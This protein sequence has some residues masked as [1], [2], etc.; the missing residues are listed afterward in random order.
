MKR[1]TIIGVGMGTGTL[2]K[3]GYEAIQEAE[4][5]LGAPRLTGLFAE[6]GK[7]ILNEYLPEGVLRAVAESGAERLAVLVS[8]DAGFYSAS[9]ALVHALWEYE[10][11]VLPGVSSR[12]FFF[13]RLKR[14]Y[15]D[16]A[17]VSCHG[18]E[19][20]LADAVRRNRLTFALTGGN[21]TELAA[22]L[23]GAGFGA[24]TA[25]AG[26]NLGAADERI[27]KTVVSSLPSENIGKLAV[28]LIENPDFDPRIRFGIPD[29]EFIRGDVPMTKAEVR[30]TTLS[31]LGLRPG[32][33]CCDVG[34]GTGSVS[35]EMAMAA[36][37]GRVYAVDKSA[38]ALSLT[39]ENA[40]NFH[41]GNIVTVSGEA[42]ACLEALPPFD[43]AFI[44][45]SSGQMQEI[46]AAILK[47]NPHA[48]IVVNAVTLEGLLSA[49]A[50]F[51]AFGLEPDIVQLSVSS[52]KPIGK[53]HMMNAQN[54]VFVLSGGGEAHE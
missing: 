38:E 23:E 28:L 4:V 51:S 1:I 54:P 15:Q 34:C 13:A 36:Y 2:T 35:V 8:G 45:G 18:R 37:Q 52:V 41:I 48:R 9:D 42:P 16:A 39:S 40:R 29:G 19:G 12:S 17:V 25:F 5:L 22:A 49:Q 33:V 32:D 6:T 3:E 43:A 26:E 27:I 24:L 50:A 30:A 53:V 21:I 7:P 11:A 14:P 20:N 44:G 31:R 10:V 47:K 46:F